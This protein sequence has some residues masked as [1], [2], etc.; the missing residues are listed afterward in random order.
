MP[1]V[2]TEGIHFDKIEPH[3]GEN[4]SA[5]VF[6]KISYHGW[7]SYTPSVFD[8]YYN[9][10]RRVRLLRLRMYSA[11]SEFIRY[12]LRDDEE[13]ECE[14]YVEFKAKLKYVF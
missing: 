3:H 5:R 13:Y 11:M 6:A 10:L 2:Q 9:I 4:I 7:F 1:I 12:L 8:L 14:Q